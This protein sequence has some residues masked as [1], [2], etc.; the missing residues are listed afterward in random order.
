MSSGN[1]CRPKKR[2]DETFQRALL[3]LFALS[4]FNFHSRSVKGAERFE[5]AHQ[6]RKSHSSNATVSL[7]GVR[8][9]LSHDSSANTPVGQRCQTASP[10][11]SSTIASRR[12][13]LNCGRGFSHTV[14]NNNT[15]ICCF[16][17]SENRSAVRR[18]TN[19]W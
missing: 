12:H 10:H 7:L 18:H 5:V 17:L 15:H 1:T 8:S 3:L 4:C 13:C 11:W 14:V 16:E 9:H 19:N 2:T 6:T